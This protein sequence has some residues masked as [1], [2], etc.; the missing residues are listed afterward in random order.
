MT[1]L[2][3]KR[4]NWGAFFLTWVW[5]LGNRTYL[6]FAS[7]LA[8]IVAATIKAICINYIPSVT[9]GIF[10][11]V[12]DILTLLFILAIHIFHGLYGTRWS[13]QH[14]QWTSEASF[15]RAQM[16]WAIVGILV[17]ALFIS[18][19]TT[20]VSKVKYSPIFQQ[21]VLIA[22]DDPN[23]QLQIGSPI[24]VSIWT[25]RGGVH[26]AGETG[27]AYYKFKA[28][29]PEG[30]AVV[31]VVAMKEQ[32]QWNIQQESAVIPHDSAKNTALLLH[33]KIIKY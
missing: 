6:G 23:L 13:W 7:F 31:T 22:Q 3:L 28:V 21:S 32:G 15:K 20:I 19:L 4:W 26:L 17:W 29:G 33:G 8:I 30:V 11:N 14:K 18:G 5:G 2:N 12:L 9:H 10:F 27:R 1:T 24:T 16:V 25:V